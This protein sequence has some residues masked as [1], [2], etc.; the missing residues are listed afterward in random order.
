MTENSDK[1]QELKW[2]LFWHSPLPETLICRNDKWPNYC[3]ERVSCNIKTLIYKTQCACNRLVWLKLEFRWKLS[4]C[5]CELNDEIV[6]K[7]VAALRLHYSDS[8]RGPLLWASLTSSYV[9]H[10]LPLYDLE[11][12]I[13]SPLARATHSVPYSELIGT[14]SNRD[15]LRRFS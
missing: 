6:C 9:Q 13:L 7:M 4:C 8:F 11:A 1:L 10:L 5:S 15:T 12:G 2:F 3:S 14:G